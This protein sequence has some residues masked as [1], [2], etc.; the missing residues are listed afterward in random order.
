MDLETGCLGQGRYALQVDE[1][2]HVSLP[3]ISPSGKPTLSR[4]PT[5]FL[6]HGV[7]RYTH[8][9][10]ICL[11]C[12]LYY[13]FER[14]ASFDLL[15]TGSAQAVLCFPSEAV[16]SYRAGPCG[17]LSTSLH[18]DLHRCGACEG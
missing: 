18:A 7:L 5:S 8:L 12:Y 1:Y 10:N 6:C 3:T 16:N 14:S 4:P 13:D 11:G 9:A 2:T 15:C 17:T